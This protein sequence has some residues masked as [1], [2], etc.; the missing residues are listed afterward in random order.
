MSFLVPSLLW[1]G[2]FLFITSVLPTF[3]GPNVAHCAWQNLPADQNYGEVTIMKRKLL[4]SSD[5]TSLSLC[6]VHLWFCRRPEQTE[7]KT[8]SHQ[9]R[10]QLQNQNNI[11]GKFLH[12]SVDIVLKWQN[13]AVISYL[14]HLS[15]GS[16]SLVLIK[17]CSSMPFQS[18]V[19]LPFPSSFALSLRF[20]VIE[21]RK[22][23]S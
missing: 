15:N 17:E 21:I 8:N 4:I 19:I 2:L 22:F 20:L 7:R 3:C 12:I 18:V 10:G 13:R 9:R 11:Q 1:N 5:P 14:L 6:C 16:F 23:T